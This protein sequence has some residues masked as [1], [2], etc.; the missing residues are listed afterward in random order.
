MAWEWLK[1][2]L[3]RKVAAEEAGNRDF[4]PVGWLGPADNPWG[5]P[6]LDVRRTTQGMI[7]T[8]EDPQCAANALSFGQDDGTGFIGVDP[9]V[10]RQVRARLRFRIDRMLADGALFIPQEMEHKW[11]LYFHRRRIICIRSWSRCVKTVSDV[12]FDGDFVEVTAIRGIF[13]SEDEE[14]DFTIRVLDFLLRSH[15]LDMVYPAPL[16]HGIEQVPADAALWCMSWFGNRAHF[17][18]PHALAGSPPEQPL[19]TYSLLHI[20][21]ARGDSSQVERLLDAGVPVDLWAGDGLAPLQW[22][23]AR[24][25]TGRRPERRRFAGFHGLASRGGVGTGGDRSIVARPGCGAPPR[26]TRAHSPILGGGARRTGNCRASCPPLNLATC[27]QSAVS[28]E[29]VFRAD[30]SFRAPAP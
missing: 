6:V 15:A 27:S 11:A 23:L 5:M 20:A 1:R 10:A 30:P 12:R 7:S 4:P 22:A 25:D 9:P 2:R 19:R 26:S 16:P 29:P 3:G 14:P 17:A 13:G 28:A 18:T 24:M 8:T 21:V